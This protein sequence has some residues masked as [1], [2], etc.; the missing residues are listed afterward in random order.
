M[1]N[2]LALLWQF[3]YHLLFIA[4]QFVCFYII[5]NYNKEQKII[6]LNSTNILTSKINEQVDKVTNYLNLSV[7][8][9]T[10]KKQ[11]A[12]LIKKFIDYDINNNLA[13]NDTLNID[14]LKYALTPVEICNSTF[15]LRDNYI[16]L[17]QGSK[18][19]IPED[20][21]IISMNGLVGMVKKVSA[22]F[23]IVMSILHSQTA[24]SCSIKRTGATG[25]L[26]WKGTDPKIMSL[27]A[28]PKHII[29]QKGD[30][31]ITSGYSTVF[32]KGIIVGKVLNAEL[33]NGN[34]TY[35]IDVLLN[36][37]PVAWDAPY[38]ITN[39]LA[40]EQRLLEA[41]VKSTANE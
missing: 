25:I 35:E 6:F 22:N 38:I 11:N 9:D 39:K 21:G 29:V 4:M 33:K 27:E 10:L 1:K 17:C 40:T 8:N 37:D 20:A 30:T 28:I 23:S 15:H 14:S 3:G 16:T 41:S 7:E 32:P 26:M 31:I 34:N 18:M 12:R 2:A 13:Q 24:I 36:N 5:I 19:G